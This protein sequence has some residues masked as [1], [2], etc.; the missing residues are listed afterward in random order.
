[1]KSS[2]ITSFFKE[3][4]KKTAESIRGMLHI[5]LCMASM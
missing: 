4:I 2:E 3:Y 5:H 1:M